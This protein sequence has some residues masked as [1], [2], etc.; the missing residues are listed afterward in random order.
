MIKTI[1]S[2]LRK[3]YP[4]E[5]ISLDTRVT[6]LF[7]EGKST[8]KV[9]YSIYVAK[10]FHNNFLNL[11]DLNKFVNAKLKMTNKADSVEDAENNIKNLNK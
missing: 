4:T 8:S 11:E 3:K 7:W 9:E 10:Q 5:F 6:N 1:I 2:K